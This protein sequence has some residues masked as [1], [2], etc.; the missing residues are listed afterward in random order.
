M[1]V[2]LAPPET[3]LPIP[4][5]RLGVAEAAI[6]GPGRKD[7]VLIELSEG[8]RVAGVF[9]RNAFSAAPVTLCRERIDGTVRGLLI[10]AGNANAVTGDRGLDDARVTTA[11]AAYALGVAE[12]SVLPFS[13]GVIGRPL[14]VDRMR[15]AIGVAAADLRPDG[16]QE[17]ARAIMTT[18]TVPKGSSRRLRL[19]CGATVTVTGIAKGVG[20]ICPNMATMLAFVATDAR[21]TQDTLRGC[22]E[23]AVAVSFNSITVDGDTSTNDSCVLVSTARAGAEEIQLGQ[24]DYPAVSEAIRDV[25]LDLAQAMIRDGEGATKFIRIEIG[26]ARDVAEARQVA[27]SIAHSPLVKTALFAGDANWG[28]I[29]MAIGKAG[30]ENLD[31][32]KVDVALDDVLLIVRGKPHPSYLEE[33][34]S[35]VVRK[36]EFSI[37]VEL[38][39]G[40]AQVTVWTCDLGYDYVRINAEY[41]T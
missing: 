8:T 33:L 14:P 36:S 35:A 17:A 26:G 6:R 21:L 1:P 40:P 12:S 39:R 13:T 16:W 2:N 29:I 11:A 37:Q 22:L 4:G 32:A 10:N 28:R 18:D 19:S 34:G 20:M 7:L 38:R 5:V 24:P 23:K 25:C 9:T 3:L 30:V 41:R 31:P 27:Y 15:A